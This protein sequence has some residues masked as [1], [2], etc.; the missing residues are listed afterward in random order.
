MLSLTALGIFSSGPVSYLLPAHLLLR[1]G[2][3]LTTPA[4]FIPLS[5]TSPCVSWVSMLWNQVNS[6]SD[7]TGR[8]LDLHTDNQQ[9]HR[10]QMAPFQVSFKYSEIFWIYPEKESCSS[11]FQS[12]LKKTPKQ[13]QQH[14]AFSLS[15]N[16]Y[17][18]TQFKK[19]RQHTTPVKNRLEYKFNLLFH[20]HI[21]HH[22]SKQNLPS[23]DII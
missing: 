18:Q 20:K 6:S 8:Y 7:Q 17:F 22:C 3:R 1:L 2:Y 19:P 23:K 13:Q 10:T 14:T 15:K 11:I 9:L 16:Q 5:C 21:R 4:G 12:L